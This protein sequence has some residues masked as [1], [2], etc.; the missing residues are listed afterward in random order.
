M[1]KLYIATALIFFTYAL[2]AQLP[3][4]LAWQWVDEVA[5]ENE[6]W[7]HG[8]QGKLPAASATLL[9]VRSL[10]VEQPTWTIDLLPLVIGQVHIDF[11]GNLDSYPVVGHL[12]LSATGSLTLSDL[13]A[14]LQL[15]TLAPML[16]LP[17]MPLNGILSIDMNRLIAKGESLTHAQGRAVI[18]NAEW[19]LM[20]PPAPLGDLTADI[21]TLDDVITADLSSQGPLEI[22]GSC[23]LN[24]DG[25]YTADIQL[26]AAANAPARLGNLLKS[27]GQ[28]TAGWYRIKTQGQIPG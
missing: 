18:R 9:N 22:K 13:D 12:R 7:L 19:L 14:A 10:M 4:R 25:Q 2:L 20:K 5:A 8:V 24:R 3:A 23:T 21:T 6:V 17:V 16:Q 28:P 11:N 15:A 27:I 1:R 26:R